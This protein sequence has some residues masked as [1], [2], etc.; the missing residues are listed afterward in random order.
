MRRVAQRDKNGCGVACVAMIAAITYEEACELMFPGRKGNYTRAKDLRTALKHYGL[1][2]G[3]RMSLKNASM[4][5]LKHNG[6]ILAH[7]ES[8]S[9]DRW[10]GSHWIVWD[11]DSQASLDPWA[12]A[13][14]AT[15]R[16]R[17]VA[18]YRVLST[19]C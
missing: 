12:G 15:R 1:T 5:D 17:W 3:R 8:V 11:S 9:E 13:G 19:R 10:A 16:V 7:T 2:L 4:S 6:I 18:Y 14:L